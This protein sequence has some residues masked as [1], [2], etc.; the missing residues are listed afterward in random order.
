MNQTGDPVVRDHHQRGLLIC[1]LRKH[2]NF[3]SL[4]LPKRYCKEHAKWSPCAAIGFEYVHGISLKHT[5]IN[6]TKSTPTKNSPN[7]CSECGEEAP[8]AP[9]DYTAKPSTFYMDRGNRGKSFSKRGGSQYWD[10]QLKL[11]GIAMEL[12]KDSIEG[13]QCYFGRIPML[14]SPGGNTPM[15]TLTAAMASQLHLDV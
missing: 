3:V 7:R 5:R 15:A 2:Q 11:A 10:L 13:G 4:V 1:K 9:F 14:I 6:G 12:N 8:D